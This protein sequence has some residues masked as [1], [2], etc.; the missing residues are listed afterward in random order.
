MGLPAAPFRDAVDVV[1][2]TIR[3]GSSRRYRAANRH[4]LH[5]AAE[6]SSLLIILASLLDLAFLLPS[7]AELWINVATNAGVA[8]IALAAY[9]ALRE[10]RHVP[11][12]PLIL[13]LLLVVDLAVAYVGRVDAAMLPVCAGYTLL[14]PVIV[15]VVVPWR[16]RFHV[17][18]LALHMGWAIA[19]VA[20]LGVPFP[21]DRP[22]IMLTLLILAVGLSVYG[23]VMNLRAR[24]LAFE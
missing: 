5:D 23:H 14:L 22:G 11:P 8:G 15:A 13:G 19:G 18:W 6:H 10:R 24:T 12:E 3:I 21:V 1:R 9:V 4:R 7:D 17:G 2:A 16:T 20:V